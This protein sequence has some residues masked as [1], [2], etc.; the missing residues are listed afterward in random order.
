MTFTIIRLDCRCKHGCRSD[1]DSNCNEAIECLEATLVTL[2]EIKF[3]L[4]KDEIEN[5][6]HGNSTGNSE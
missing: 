4:F 3:E 6:C 1:G 2:L 5:C